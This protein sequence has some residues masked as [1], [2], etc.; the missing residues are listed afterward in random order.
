MKNP[1]L[2][3][4]KP[5]PLTRASASPL[6]TRLEAAYPHQVGDFFKKPEHPIWVVASE[7]HYSLLFATTASVQ[8]RARG[9]GVAPSSAC[10]VR[11][12]TA[13]VVARSC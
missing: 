10:L 2:Y 8:A 13:A 11:Q 1:W 4:L 6:T 7:S 12:G 5:T 3:G 9:E